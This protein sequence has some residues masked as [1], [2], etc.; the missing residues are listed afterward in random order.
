MPIPNVANLYQRIHKGAEGGNEFARFLKLLLTAE[1]EKR[2]ER[3]I[4]VSD[5][6]GDYK[7]VDAYLPGDEDFPSFI[8]GFQFKF[9]PSNL[10]SNQK[11]DI[12]NA[13]EGA[14]SE[15]EFIQEFVLIT[16]EDFQKHQEIWY[17]SLKE[18]YESTYWAQSNGLHRK[19]GL[20]LLHWGHTK[21]I[22]LAL[23]HDHISIHYFPELFPLGIGKFK[24]ASAGIDC[25]ICNWLPFEENKFG[26]HQSYPN[27]RPNLTTD[28]V[29]DFHFVNSSPEIFLME[30][31][32]VH[33][34]EMFT[35]LKGIPADKLLKSVG[36]IEFEI[37]FDKPIN[38]IDFDDPMIFE[39]NKPTR[40]KLQ[41]K[42]FTSNC[43]GNCATIKFWF[44]FN[45]YSIPTESFYLSF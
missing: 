36:T 32:E 45:D 31:I 16:P 15:N 27:S 20:K 5:A 3:F 22:E 23:K 2:G 35:R 39:S 28:P 6:S 18:K 40:F 13:I 10:N 24:L 4:S 41:L 1:Y 29:F 44:Y 37:D 38:T 42:D 25:K 30:K 34:E 26:Y 17:D 8:K 12:I 14:I 43:K 9:I 11:Q 33:I 7:K 19:G 21:I